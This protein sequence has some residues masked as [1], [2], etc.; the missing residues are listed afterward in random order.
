MD[1]IS[2]FDRLKTSETNLTFEISITTKTDEKYSNHIVST[3]ELIREVGI[4]IT[5]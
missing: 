1:I 2:Y 5:G 3:L 4:E